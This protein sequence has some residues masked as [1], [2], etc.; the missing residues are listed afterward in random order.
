MLLI[1]SNPLKYFRVQIR[2]RRLIKNINN[3][4]GNE[5]DIVVLEGVG[6]GRLYYTLM[7]LRVS[8]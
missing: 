8:F 2:R 4:R 5:L 1:F 6:C 7:M 3:E